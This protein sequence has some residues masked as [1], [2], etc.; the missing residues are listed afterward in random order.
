MMNEKN[1]VMLP[2]TTSPMFYLKDFDWDID[3]D[4]VYELFDELDPIQG[5]MTINEPYTRYKNMTR[6]ERN[7]RIRDYFHHCPGA[8]YDLLGLP[9]GRFIYVADEDRDDMSEDDV[10]DDMSNLFGYCINSVH[11]KRIQ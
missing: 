10:V 1:I 11:I 5:A 6:K 3:M 8:L 4:E 9:C 7:D 2:C